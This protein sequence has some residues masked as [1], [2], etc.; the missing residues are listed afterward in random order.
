MNR[1][2]PLIDG[3]D[4]VVE[5]ERDLMHYYK[6]AGDGASHQSMRHHMH[7]NMERHLAHI[8]RL[9]LRR[10]RLEDEARQGRLGDFIQSLGKAVETMAAAFPMEMIV[11]E[12][13]PSIALFRMRE[14]QLIGYFQ[15][16]RTIADDETRQVIDAAIA[17]CQANVDDL[18]AVQQ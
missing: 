3:I 18:S 9:E 16:L 4:R 13:E 6:H 2:K 7:V 11:T 17:D 5:M 15:E 10:S 12:T 8:G 14:E 1:L